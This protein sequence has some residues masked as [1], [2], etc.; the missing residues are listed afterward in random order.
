MPSILFIYKNQVL[1]EPFV[2]QFIKN[3]Y[4]LE[5]LFK[6]KLYYNQFSIWQKIVN[7]FYRNVLKNNSYPITANHA[8]FEKYCKRSLKQLG[9]DH[10]DYCVVIRADLVPE[11]VLKKARK[12]SDK[13]VDFQL[14]G[15]SVSKKILSYR[16]YFDEI[17]V[18]DKNDIKDNPG[19]HLKFITNCFFGKDNTD[20][21][22][23]YDFFYIGQY[24]ADRHQKITNLFTYL[25]ENTIK[26]N[27]LIYL[28]TDRS[29][30][31][32]DSRIKNLIDGTSYQ[33]NLDMVKKSSILIDL[34][35]DEHSGLSLRFFEALKYR[36]KMITNNP[37][38]KEY[39]FYH[40]DNIFVT[41]FNNFDRLSDF[42]TKP[43]RPID[44]EITD[45]Y[46]FENWIKKLLA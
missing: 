45:Q 19:Y 20:Y 42:L 13:M 37:T 25:D 6:D 44:H 4:D 11:F 43:Y 5:I 14:D 21:M 33:E 36:K 8:N 10:F 35:R 40:P 23:E 28:N 27:P 16:N 32:T 26:T 39:D 1:G 34:K 41:D 46:E 12:I 18:F 29:Y 22:A 38:V 3:S 9:N 17:F 7:I 30:V 24:L 31:N 15:I 2:E